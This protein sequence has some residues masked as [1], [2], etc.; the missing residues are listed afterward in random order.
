MARPR[1]A[2]SQHVEE[3]DA[4]QEIEELEATEPDDEE[5]DEPEAD[6]PRGKV[7]KAAAIRAAIAAGKDSPDEGIAFIRDRFGL[8]VSKQHWSASRSQFKR[9]EG[10]GGPKAARAPRKAKQATASEGVPT[11][12]PRART[13]PAAQQ[14]PASESGMISDLAAVKALVKRLGAQQVKE[15]ADLFED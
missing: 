14:A 5:D 9:K 10:L 1:K 11:P 7:T 15:I 4:S 3:E 13:A 8:D 2:A 12:A 6:E